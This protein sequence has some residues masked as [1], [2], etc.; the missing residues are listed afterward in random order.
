MK[1]NEL[2]EVEIDR[3]LNGSMTN[4][5]KEAFNSRI[6]K[7][8]ELLKEVELQRSIIWAVRKEQLG[9]IIQKKEEGIT[10]KRSIRNLVFSVGSFALAASILGFF[11]VGYINKDCENIANRFYASY[12]YT[13]IPSR[14][15]EKMPLTKSDSIFFNALHQLESGHSKVAI[16][17]LENLKNSSSEMLAAS[18]QAVK[19][20]LSLA[21][22]KNGQKKKARILLLEISNDLNS[23]FKIKAKDLLKEL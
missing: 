12:T 18:E 7:D 22:L 5:E 3:Y 19:W 2:L 14:G 8:S 17:Q 1:E 13:P 10:K 9:K 20:Y 15:G 4:E 16:H 23:E 6:E 21:Y 11:Y